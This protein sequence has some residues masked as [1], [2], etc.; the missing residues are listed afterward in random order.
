[1][2]SRSLKVAAGNQAAC[3]IRFLAAIRAVL[4]RGAT[5]G[6]QSACPHARRDGP[7]GGA[8]HYRASAYGRIRY[9]RGR[10]VFPRRYCMQ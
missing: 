1:M 5:W 8:R 9:G 7:S 3:L 4:S 2:E 10:L 6:E